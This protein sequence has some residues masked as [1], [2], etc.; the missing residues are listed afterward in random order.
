MLLNVS[1]HLLKFRGHGSECMTFSLAFSVCRFLCHRKSTQCIEIP[2]KF[3]HKM[4]CFCVVY[5]AMV[6]CWLVCFF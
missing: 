2:N 4:D 1:D 5:S 3:Q 6:C